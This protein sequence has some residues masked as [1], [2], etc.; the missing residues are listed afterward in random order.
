MPVV[1]VTGA[2]GFVGRRL[3]GVLSAS[4]WEVVALVRGVEPSSCAAWEFRVVGNLAEEND[5]SG[6]LRGLDA[7]IHLAA[8]VHVMRDKAAD[9]LKEFRR[10]N[11]AG[12]ERLARSAARAGVRRFVFVSTAK[13]HGEATTGN[14]P[15]RESDAPRPQD[16]YAISKWEAEQALWRVAAETGLEVVVVRPPLVYGPGV[17]GNFLRLLRWVKRGVPLPFSSVRNRRS[18]VY[19]GNLADALLACVEQPQAAGKTYLLSD[20]QVFST[21]DLIRTLASPMGLT[22]RLLPCPPLLLGLGGRLLGKGGEMERLMGSLELDSGLIRSE[23]KWTPPFGARQGLEETVAWFER[24]S[25]H[26]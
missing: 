1:G 6:A 14:A 17:G 22:P 13:V 16:P 9:P 4:G 23:L 3:C 12:T 25:G 5:L 24:E 2:A 15:F 26:A 8:R 18:L 19:V 7:V 10:V 21:P 20:D 11:A